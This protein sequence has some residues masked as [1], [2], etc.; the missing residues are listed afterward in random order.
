MIVSI[1]CFAAIFEFLVRGLTTCMLLINLVSLVL[2]Q[3]KKKNK[4]KLQSSSS[5]PKFI[6]KHRAEPSTPLL[7]TF[8]PTLKINQINLRVLTQK[9][10]KNPIII[11][12]AKNKSKRVCCGKS[13][14][15]Y[16]YIYTC[17]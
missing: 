11:M 8:S 17:K 5:S 1:P 16:I 13:V 15:I 12:I 10:I 3:K 9:Y 7:Y 2:W 6:L 14:L 4:H